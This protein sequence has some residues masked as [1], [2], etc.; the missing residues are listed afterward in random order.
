MQPAPPNSTFVG[1]L[2]AMRNVAWTPQGN[3]LYTTGSFQIWTASPGSNTTTAV[4]RPPQD[5]GD[6]IAS[7]CP[8]GRYIVFTSNRGNGAFGIWRTDVD[9]TNAKQLTQG[10]DTAVPACSPDGKWVVYSSQYSGRGGLWRIPIDGGEPVQLT[11][12]V[13]AYNPQVSPDGRWI[14]FSGL[15]NFGIIPF[16]GGAPVKTF[17]YA[18]GAN[19]DSPIRLIRW[20]PDGQALT[21]IV[22][23]NGFRTSG[24]SRSTEGRPSR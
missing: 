2:V 12:I 14:A 1:P 17:D 23:K 16:A 11:S 9:G 18:P 15:Q 4:T 24:H 19:F 8:D 13:S 22:T 7:A 3:I 21:Y 20:A 10:I 5:R 6:L